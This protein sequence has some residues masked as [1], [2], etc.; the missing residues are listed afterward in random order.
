MSLWSSR[1]PLVCPFWPR[2]GHKYHLKGAGCRGGGDK[3]KLPREGTGYR[4]Q[5]VTLWTLSLLIVS[6]WTVSLLTVS[7][8][9]V[10]LHWGC[11]F[12]DCFCVVS[13]LTVSLLIVSLLTV[14]LLTVSWGQT[15]PP[16][17]FRFSQSFRFLLIMIKAQAKPSKTH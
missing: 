6:L 11:F 12:V 7:L 5:R 3:G 13:L 8:W 10:S 17:P 4:L 14:S 9:T 15:F 2:Y 1:P 16:Y